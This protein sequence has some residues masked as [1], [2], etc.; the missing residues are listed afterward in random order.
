MLAED[1]VAAAATESAVVLAPDDYRQAANIEAGSMTLSRIRGHVNLRATVVGGIAF[2]A[3]FV[4]G[5]NE[6]NV[7]PSAFASYITGDTLFHRAVMVSVNEPVLL[8]LDI[9]ARRRLENDV[10]VMSVSA[11]AQAITYQWGLRCLC[12]GN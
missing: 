3:I 8:E 4:I 5:E 7:A 1:Q 2:V 6:A 11:V 10:V 12:T 9:K